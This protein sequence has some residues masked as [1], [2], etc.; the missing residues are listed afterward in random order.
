MSNQKTSRDF[1]TSVFM[2]IGLIGGAM[3]LRLGLALALPR[4]IWR[5]EVDYVLIGRNL[6]SGQGFTNPDGSPHLVHPPGYPMIVG[7]IARL[8]G[9]LEWAS[10]LAYVLFGG[11]LLFPVFVLV[12][13]LYGTSTAWLAA[14]LVAV[15]PALN[16]SVLYW[17]SM[18]EPLYMCLLYAGL[19]ALL[20]G[21]EEKR[22]RLLPAAGLAFGLAYLVRPEA[23]GHVGVSMLVILTWLMRC[24][25]GILRQ[26][27]WAIGGFV[28]AFALVAAPYVWYL[29]AHTGRWLLSGKGG[30]T[31]E[32]GKAITQRDRAAM[33]EIVT[34]LWGTPEGFKFSIVQAILAD[35]RA[36]ARRVLRNEQV[37]SR[38]L[39]MARVYI[40]ALLPLITLALF[41][42]P[43]DRRRA[44]HEAFLVA[45]LIPFSVFLAFHIEP[46][47]FAPALPVLLLW[48]AQGARELGLWLCQTAVIWRDRPLAG[49]RTTALVQWGPAGLLV[50][51]LLSLLPLTA[52]ANLAS[53]PWRYKTTGLWLRGHTPADAKV[54]TRQT[55]IS[56]YAERVKVKVPR[57]DWPGV[58][59]AARA[60]GAGYLV[61]DEGELRNVWPQLAFLLEAP[62]PELTLE[63]IFEGGRSRTRVYRFGAP[64]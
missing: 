46:R 31:W 54:M 8:V 28:V 3:L 22:W 11:L 55:S 5:D 53:V 45:A 24:G 52:Q 64:S 60:H 37:L 13:R 2:L 48:V 62:P 34:R 43:W 63:R 25:S 41:R 21:L 58:L 49:G 35:P 42:T 32:L 33:D 6:L 10:D 27:C 23:I 56:F 29:H 40:Y 12:Q 1:A 51:L 61:V 15:Y 9:D 14:L 38:E 16:V 4:V 7:T 59:E 19:A 57:T 36:F 18:T 47:F 20:M 50:V 17:G 44:A 26:A 30:V 39:Y